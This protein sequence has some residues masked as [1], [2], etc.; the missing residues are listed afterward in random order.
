MLEIILIIL[1]K[2]LLDLIA[3]YKIHKL[4]MEI[5]LVRV[6]YLTKG[7]YKENWE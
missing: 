3:L 5:V 7:K 4:P 2:L 6:K 1:K